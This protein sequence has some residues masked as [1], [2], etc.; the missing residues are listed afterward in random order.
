MLIQNF[1]H[2]TQ[3]LQ[4]TVLA[5]HKNGLIKR[6]ELQLLLLVEKRIMITLIKEGVRNGSTKTGGED[7]LVMGMMKMGVYITLNQT[8]E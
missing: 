7:T 1:I 3:V 5:L 2:V 6:V 4:L 8:Q